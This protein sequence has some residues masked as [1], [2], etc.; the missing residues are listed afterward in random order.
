MTNNSIVSEGDVLVA[1]TAFLAQRGLVPYQF[2]VAVGRGL[3]STDT[4]AHLRHGNQGQRR[5]VV[6]VRKMFCREAVKKY[7]YSGARVARFLGVT[8][9][10]GNR[11]ASSEKLIAMDQ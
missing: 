2:S 9:S 11:Y 5:L 8:T 1:T 4:T 10:L 7:G 3:K 6:R